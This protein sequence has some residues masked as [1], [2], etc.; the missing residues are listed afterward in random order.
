M[1]KILI[2]E[3]DANIGF[4]IEEELRLEGHE[5]ASALDGKTGLTLIQNYPPDLDCGLHSGH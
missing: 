1:A 3:D 5:V 4:L 2:I